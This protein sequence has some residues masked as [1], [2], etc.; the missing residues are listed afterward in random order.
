MDGEKRQGPRSFAVADVGFD[1]KDMHFQG[2][3]TDL[4]DGGLYIDTINPL[5]EGSPISFRFGLP[6][7]ESEC[8]ISGEGQVVWMA[9]MQGMGIRFIRMSGDDRDRLKAYL[10][11]R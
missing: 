5:P 3:I 7:D 10:S 2:R 8:P 6:G 1:H 4:S 11:R 9:H